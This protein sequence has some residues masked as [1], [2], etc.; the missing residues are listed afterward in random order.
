M[1]EEVRVKKFVNHIDHVAWI[2]RLENLEENVARFEKI[3]GTRFEYHEN[4]ITGL[5]IYLSWEA[6]LEIVAPSEE[7]TEFNQALHDRLEQHGEG[8]HAVVFGIRDMDEH[9]ARLKALGISLRPQAV[10]RST[11]PWVDRVKVKERIG[12][13]I[14]NTWFILGDIDYA[15]GIVS[16]EDA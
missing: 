6:G 13:A 7:R 2:S 9:E 4:P 10:K 12:P 5:I 11:A 1:R 16:F 14:L 3:S 15:D 8:V